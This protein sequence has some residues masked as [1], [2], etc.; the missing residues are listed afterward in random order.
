MSVLHTLMERDR[1][2]TRCAPPS[3]ALELHQQPARRVIG[4]RLAF[5]DSTETGTRPGAHG[6]LVPEVRVDGDAR[7]AADVAQVTRDRPRGIGPEA[8]TTRAGHQEHVDS[9]RSAL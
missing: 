4:V 1:R 2:R 9:A 5:R 3:L 8:A 7:P 6:S